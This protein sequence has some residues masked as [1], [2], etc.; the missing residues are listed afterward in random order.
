MKNKKGAIFLAAIIMSS[1]MSTTAEAFSLSS[2]NPFNAIKGPAD[3]DP[4][5]IKDLWNENEEKGEDLFF[6]K[7]VEEAVEAGK[8]DFSDNFYK[9]LASIIW[10]DKE[11]DSLLKI[12]EIEKLWNKSISS[13]YP[14]YL[15]EWIRIFNEIEEDIKEEK[16]I[17]NKTED[18]VEKS[19]ED[20]NETIKEKEKEKEKEVSSKNE[21]ESKIDYVKIGD[22]YFKETVNVVDGKTKINREKISKQEAEKNGFKEDS[23]ISSHERQEKPIVIEVDTEG[24]EEK[25]SNVQIQN[26]KTI[27]FTLNGND[28]YPQFEDTGVPSL[29]HDKLAYADIKD[30]IKIISKKTGKRTFD[31]SIS[32]MFIIDN[33]L[34][35]LDK[36]A[37]EEIRAMDIQVLERLSNNPY[38]NEDGTYN[39]SYVN[40]YDLNEL[41]INTSVRFRIQDTRDSATLN[42]VDYIERGGTFNLF[43]N[44]EEVRLQRP[45]IIENSRML[46]PIREIAVKL[47]AE[48]HWN[49]QSREATIIGNGSTMIFKEGDNGVLI[50]GEKED[51]GVS[52]KIDEERMFAP[53]RYIVEKL[54]ANMKWDARKFEVHIDKE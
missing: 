49:E 38:L 36:P 25:S 31:N 28:G 43:V 45:P 8:K 13:K 40:I 39:I 33:K 23:L 6:Q 37:G 17:E 12:L 16:N 30:A 22:N 34:V 26:Q 54:G 32:F 1:S 21:K 14:F 4:F 3:N 2:L 7:I 19:Q 52:I 35:I 5:K 46:F 41:L 44:G 29:D 15:D 10:N 11:K 24:K 18:K 27:F 48:V 51:L 20:K 50:N 9:E 42:L 47:G 53:V